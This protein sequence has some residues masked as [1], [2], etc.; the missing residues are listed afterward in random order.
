MGHVQQPLW[1]PLPSPRRPS[2]EPP[3]RQS[4]QPPAPGR[5]H[6]TPWHGGEKCGKKSSIGSGWFAWA[7]TSTSETFE[8][9]ITLSVS[10]G[11]TEGSETAELF[12]HFSTYNFSW[13]QK[14][15]TFLGLGSNIFNFFQGITISRHAGLWCRGGTFDPRRL[16]LPSIAVCGRWV[17]F[18]VFRFFSF[19]DF[20]GR[21]VLALSIATIAEAQHQQGK[22]WKSSENPEE[23][24]RKSLEAEVDVTATKVDLWCGR[25]L[26][27]ALDRCFGSKSGLWLLDIVTLGLNSSFSVKVFHANC[28]AIIVIIIIISIMNTLSVNHRIMGHQQTCGFQLWL[29]GGCK[30][31]VQRCAIPSQLGELENSSTRKS[32]IT[33]CRDSTGDGHRLLNRFPKRSWNEFFPEFHEFPELEIKNN[34]N[35]TKEFHMLLVWGDREVFNWLCDI[36]IE[37]RN[38]AKHDTKTA[39]GDI[40][41]GIL[42]GDV[43]FTICVNTG[44]WYLDHLYSEW[45]QN[46]CFATDGCSW[47]F[48][49]CWFLHVMSLLEAS[50]NEIASLVVQLEVL[51]LQ[52]P[53]VNP[54]P[55]SNLKFL[56]SLQNTVAPIFRTLS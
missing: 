27:D 46:T 24:T 7:R 21:S 37:G 6:R 25:R 10:K 9:K 23:I 1:P 16:E 47:T 31:W 56:E 50:L 2:L 15:I 14:G 40:W 55:N 20:S 5:Q 42:V 44:K 17:V 13:S 8:K 30:K 43:F 33:S 26:G 28:C 22:C 53:E 35:T 52:P 12:P 45:D 29:A 49:C 11:S 41:W 19:R 18:S 3:H 38:R 4:V 34:K 32:S 51:S 48:G 54:V 39:G 36:E